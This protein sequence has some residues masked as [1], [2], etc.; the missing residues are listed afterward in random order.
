MEMEYK[1]KLELE[2]LKGANAR[3][4]ASAS[5]EMKK[6]IQSAQEDRKDARIKKQTAE[7]SKLIS[8]RKGERGEIQGEGEGDDFINQLTNM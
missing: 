1:F 8:Q 4:V 7:Q 2:K 5:S 6:A 3:D